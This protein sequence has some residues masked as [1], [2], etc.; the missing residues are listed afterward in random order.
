MAA[1]PIDCQVKWND[2]QEKVFVF[3][4]YRTSLMLLPGCHS[5]CLRA[6]CVF[7]VMFKL[8]FRPLSATTNSDALIWDD[9]FLIRWHNDVLLQFSGCVAQVE[10]K[11][12][13]LD[14]NL[15]RRLVQNQRSN[16]VNVTGNTGGVGG[17]WALG[18][19]YIETVTR[20]LFCS[21]YLSVNHNHSLSIASWYSYH[22]VAQ[23]P[24]C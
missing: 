3:T 2:R 8:M 12:C 5:N 4:Q 23:N 24:P 13:T 22:R 20:G 6:Y 19:I 18:E 11:G 14:Q 1:F 7:G 17:G 21:D 9:F 16:A 10:H 15:F